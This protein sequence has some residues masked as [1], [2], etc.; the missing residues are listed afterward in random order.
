MVKKKRKSGIPL[1]RI[2]WLDAALN[3]L[4][5]EGID[6]V[7]VERLAKELGVTKGSFYWHF[8]NRDDLLE[9]LLDYH[10]LTCTQPGMDE[11]G[12]L[13]LPA[14][15]LLEEV[16]R[17]V[18]NMGIS[19]F[20]KAIYAWSLF[21]PKAHKYMSKTV[22]RRLSFVRNLF[23]QAGFEGDEGKARTRMFVYRQ[24]G[25]LL[26][27]IPEKKGKREPYARIRMRL[28]TGPPEK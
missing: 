1:T 23:N 9:S 6:R 26:L 18:E 17:I 16:E 5:K 2:D 19:G 12:K 8:K 28:L 15:Q 14:D 10:H 21:D 7:K 27:E 11:I 25:R 4:E 24:I 13:D 22:D 20:E 3:T